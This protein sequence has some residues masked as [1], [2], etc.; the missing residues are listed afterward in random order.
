MWNALNNFKI[1]VRAWIPEENKMIYSDH[2][3]EDYGLDGVYF[4]GFNTF[5]NLA[6]FEVMDT[7]NDGDPYIEREVKEAVI[8]P[9]IQLDIQQPFEIGKR[10]EV[11]VGDF[12]YFDSGYDKGVGIVEFNNDDYQPQFCLVYNYGNILDFSH[13]ITKVIGNVYE[14]PELF[15]KGLI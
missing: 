9:C 5:G 15:N 14:N 12:V 2:D 1:E 8:M 4:W 13:G 7:A 3:P 6:L 10:N 11:Y